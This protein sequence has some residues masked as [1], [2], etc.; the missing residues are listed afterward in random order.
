VPVVTL[1]Y[2][3]S[4]RSAAG[5]AEEKVEATSLGDA[6][7]AVQAFR[8]DQPRFAQVLAVC[9]YVVD[10]VPVGKRPHDSVLL[11]DGAQVEVLPPFAGG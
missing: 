8:T 10:D 9:S 5:V 2:W 1:R 11:E 4:A 3:A 6:L 7:R